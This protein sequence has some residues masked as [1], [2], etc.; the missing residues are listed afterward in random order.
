MKALDL[1]IM[2]S[3]VLKFFQSKI[4]KRNT[5]KMKSNEVKNKDCSVHA[6]ACRI[7]ILNFLELLLLE[8]FKTSNLAI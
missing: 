8:N 5:I 3:G 4:S 1:L 2:K 6:F 7:V